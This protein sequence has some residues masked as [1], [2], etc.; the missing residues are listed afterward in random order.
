M[1]AAVAHNVERV[2]VLSTDKSV[3]PINAMGMSK[4][5]MEKCMISKARMQNEGETIFCAT[6]YGNAMASRDSLIPL[7]VSQ[8]KKT[9]R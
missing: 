6:R 1:N 9:N 5:L 2:I 7:F 3:H 4:A 8:L